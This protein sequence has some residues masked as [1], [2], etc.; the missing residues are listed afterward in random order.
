M[1]PDA[2][3]YL[4]RTPTRAEFTAARRA[5]HRLAAAGQATIFRVRPPKSDG[6]RGSPHVILA[7]PRNETT[8][9]RSCT[10]SKIRTQ[11]TPWASCQRCLQI[12]RSEDHLLR[13]FDGRRH[14]AACL[15]QMRCGC[16]RWRRQSR[17]R[18]ADDQTQKP[19]GCCTCTSTR[20]QRYRWRYWRIPGERDLASAIPPSPAVPQHR[21]GYRCHGRFDYREC[22]SK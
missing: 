5:A 15:G 19:S 3:S 17:R 12:S 9:T 7:R 2:F 13:I 18:P 16:R 1:R 11:S 6:G 22:S 8:P 10:R 4:R 20:T 14:S 21:L